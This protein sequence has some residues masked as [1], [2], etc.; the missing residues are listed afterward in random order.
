MS[1]VD[2]IILKE[3]VKYCSHGYKEENEVVK[4]KFIAVSD[5]AA[6]FV[7]NSGQLWA[8]G[9]QPQID[10]NSIEPKKVKFFEGRTVSEIACGSNF[11]VAAVRKLLNL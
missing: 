11:N 8:S 10:V 5:Q 7:T 9:N 1:V 3:E 6:L 4:V 2:S